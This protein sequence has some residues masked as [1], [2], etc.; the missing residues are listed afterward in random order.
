MKVTNDMISIFLR[1]YSMGKG[2]AYI[3]NVRPALEAIFEHIGCCESHIRTER[4][5]KEP[6]KEA[7]PDGICKCNAWMGTQWNPTEINFPRCIN[8]KKLNLHWEIARLNEKE[9]KPILKC[10]K[11]SEMWKGWYYYTLENNDKMPGLHF[12]GGYLSK[13]ELLTHN[14]NCKLI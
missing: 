4:P 10:Y 7:K 12:T 3:G 8:C 13:K 9:K 14:A 2:D 11:L 6:I 5:L 1:K